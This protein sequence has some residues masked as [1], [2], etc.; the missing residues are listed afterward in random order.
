[1]EYIN[2][3]SPICASDSIQII[4]ISSAHTFFKTTH[5]I[6]HVGAQI[7]TRTNC[8]HPSPIFTLCQNIKREHANYSP[9]AIQ[10]HHQRVSTS[11]QMR[12]CVWGA[13]EFAKLQYIRHRFSRW[14]FRCSARRLLRKQASGYGETHRARE[15]LEIAALR[16]WV[17][18]F[19]S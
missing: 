15:R 5:L 10:F 13:H 18:V 7:D 2:L 6:M 8:F 1:M 9:R 19:A 3:F 4:Y 12:D 17:G 16:E 11:F 14:N